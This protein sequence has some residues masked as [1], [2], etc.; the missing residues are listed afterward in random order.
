MT[1]LLLAA[2]SAALLT[3]G[4]CGGGENKWEEAGRDIGNDFKNWGE[5]LGGK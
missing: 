4:A 1:R 3:I 5:S 2:I